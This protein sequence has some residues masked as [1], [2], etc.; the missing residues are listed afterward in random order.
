MRAW[1]FALFASLL[2]LSGCDSSSGCLIDSDC[3]DFTLV[4]IDSACVEPGNVRRDA[5]PPE[6]D[7]GRR[8]DAGPQDAGGDAG[9]DAGAPVCADVTGRWAITTI[10]GTCGTAAAGFATDFAAAS[11]ACMYTATSADVALMPAL[12]GTFTVNT[13]NTLGGSLN[14]GGT[15]AMYCTGTVNADATLTVV[16]G[17][18]TLGLTRG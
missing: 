17:A 11:A 6:M 12:D 18:C 4:C 16:C 14:A 1:H 9:G 7:A 5:A 3:A 2:A 10:T 13:D 15:G 8:P